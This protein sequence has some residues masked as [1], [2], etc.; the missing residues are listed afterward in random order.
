MYILCETKADASLSNDGYEH[1][2]ESMPHVK[3]SAEIRQTWQ[4]SNWHYLIASGI[5]PTLTGVSFEDFV[6][7]NIFTPLNMT[8]AGLNATV[9]SQTGLWTD[10]SMRVGVNLTACGVELRTGKL[11]EACLGSVERFGKWTDTDGLSI[12]GAGG[13]ILDLNDMVGFSYPPLCSLPP[14]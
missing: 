10:G 1:L 13:A 8:S 11:D 2:I 3:P 14:R 12:A 7:Q 4:Y 5:V 6:Q 9:A